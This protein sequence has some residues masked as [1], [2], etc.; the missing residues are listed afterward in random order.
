MLLFI[1][2]FIC[3]YFSLYTFLCINLI[4]IILLFFFNIMMFLIIFSFTFV[5]FQYND[6]KSGAGDSGNYNGGVEQKRFCNF[7]W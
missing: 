4:F 7:L 1:Y 2:W 6:R 5:S 3:V